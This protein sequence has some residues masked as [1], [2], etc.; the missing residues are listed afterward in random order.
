M[1]SQIKPHCFIKNNFVTTGGPTNHTIR[2]LQIVRIIT[3]E[4]YGWTNESHDIARWSPP[5]LTIEGITMVQE[6]E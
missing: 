3:Q 4:G 5:A 1:P 2:R 6:V